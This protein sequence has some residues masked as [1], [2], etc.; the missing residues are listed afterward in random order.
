MSEFKE[1]SEFMRLV[2]C[3]NCF[4]SL[5]LMELRCSRCGHF[6]GT[7]VAKAIAGV[8]LGLAG[9]LGLVGFATLSL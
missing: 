1:P 8:A 9:L 6:D 4:Q 5:S 7:R 2:H 3:R